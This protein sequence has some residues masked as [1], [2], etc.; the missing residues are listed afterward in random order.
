[1]ILR[2]NPIFNV[3]LFQVKLY[4][5]FSK[6]QAQKGIEECVSSTK[7]SEQKKGSTHVFQVCILVLFSSKYQKKYMPK[8]IL[9]NDK[10]LSS[11][12]EKIFSFYKHHS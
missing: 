3:Y 12:S 1:M 4:E 10:F 7:A 11:I 8:S 6:S 2:R 9:S 5:D